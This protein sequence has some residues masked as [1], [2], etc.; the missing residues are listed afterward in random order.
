MQYT[1][2]RDPALEAALLANVW[3]AYNLVHV[4]KTHTLAQLA[5][6]PE[7]IAIRAQFAQLAQ[8][9]TGVELPIPQKAIAD[10]HA[11]RAQTLKFM[12]K[13]PPVAAAPLPGL[14]QTVPDPYAARHECIKK[15][16]TEK[17]IAGAVHLCIEQMS[18]YG[19]LIK[20]I[21]F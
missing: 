21:Y 1:I 19:D 7:C 10:Y 17:N 18:A 11:K 9:T 13:K 15:R 3:R 4:K 14:D 6:T 16:L 5:D 2:V 20:T 12:A 8:S